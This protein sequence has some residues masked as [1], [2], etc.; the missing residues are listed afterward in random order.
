MKWSE[1]DELDVIDVVRVHSL[2]A[3]LYQLSVIINGQEHFVEDRLGRPITSHNK[4]E[5][6]NLFKH[7]NVEKMVL[8]HR[9]AYDEMVGQ[10]VGEGNILEVPLGIPFN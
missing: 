7:K 6:Q 1:L 9:S 2:A 5:L 4:L 8:Y 3:N 10:P